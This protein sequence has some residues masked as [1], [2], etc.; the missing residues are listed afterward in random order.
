MTKQKPV[1]SDAVAI[2]EEWRGTKVGLPCT[3]VPSV[4]NLDKARISVLRPKLFRLANQVLI[5]WSFTQYKQPS[6]KIGKMTPRDQ[7]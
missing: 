4:G 2:M 6:L 7:K 1:V 3:F 5:K